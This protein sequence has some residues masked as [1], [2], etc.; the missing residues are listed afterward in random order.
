MLIKP[1]S[2]ISSSSKHNRVALRLRVVFMDQLGQVEHL[3]EKRDPTVIVSVVLRNFLWSVKVTQL[4]RSWVALGIRLGQ[5]V[6]L[7]GPGRW[8]SRSHLVTFKLN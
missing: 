4:V 2:N 3:V 8:N 7:L 1:V 5:R 6:H